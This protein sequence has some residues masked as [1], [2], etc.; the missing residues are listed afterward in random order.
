M[1]PR[2]RTTRLQPQAAI[3]GHGALCGAYPALF[4]SGFQPAVVLKGGGGPPAAERLRRG[5]VVLQFAASTLFLIG[6]LTMHRQ[7]QHI[8]DRDPGY[9]AEGGDGEA[10]LPTTMSPMTKIQVEK[11]SPVCTS[12]ISGGLFYIGLGTDIS[13]ERS[14]SSSADGRPASS[15]RVARDRSWGHTAFPGDTI[16]VFRNWLRFVTEAR[17]CTAVLISSRDLYRSAH[18]DLHESAD[19][20]RNRYCSTGPLSPLGLRTEANS[21]KP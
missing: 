16:P 6:T 17:T 2:R 14:G 7:L 20:G 1:T 13:R 11:I 19:P 15:T 3:S 12:V 21:E 9:D 18:L 5:L 4:L 8:A 10:R